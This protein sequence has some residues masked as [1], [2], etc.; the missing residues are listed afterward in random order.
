MDLLRE[1][2]K[3]VFLNRSID[4]LSADSSRPLSSTREKLEKLY[5]KRMPLYKKYADLTVYSEG[6]AF[7]TANSVLEMIL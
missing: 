1:N 2:G 5:E 4:F 3:L 7:E 6:T